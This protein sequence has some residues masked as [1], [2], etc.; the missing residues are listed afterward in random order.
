MGTHSPEANKKRS[1][2]QKRAWERRKAQALVKVIAD[3]E[4]GGGAAVN[5]RAFS[6]IH[7]RTEPSLVQL[8]QNAQASL[9]AVL[10]RLK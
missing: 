7:I 5:Q 3:G 6:P 9:A 2:G 8:I 10:E 1:E 4:A